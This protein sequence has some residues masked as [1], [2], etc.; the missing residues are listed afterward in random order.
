MDA[1]VREGMN[2]HLS[3]MKYYSAVGALKSEALLNQARI[4]NNNSCICG[5]QGLA[6]GAHE[7]LH[8]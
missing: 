6:S 8:S 5:E 2:V 1:F 3:L 7:A 4:H